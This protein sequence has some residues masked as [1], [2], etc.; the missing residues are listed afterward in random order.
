MTGGLAAAGGIW[1]L[2]CTPAHRDA[3]VEAAQELAGRLGLADAMAWRHARI[4]GASCVQLE[5]HAE[6]WARWMPGHDTLGLRDR[7]GAAT[8]LPGAAALQRE[9]FVAMLGG[10][11]PFA[12][13][14]VGE[15]GSAL[16]MRQYTAEAALRT[17]LRFH[18]TGLERPADCWA[19]QE[20]SGFVLRPN[21]SLIEALR[22]ATQPAQA[23]PLYSFSCYRATE[24][25]L[26]LA[27]AQELDA[28]NP[29]LLDSLQGQWRRRAV[30]SGRFHDVFLREFGSTHEPL[31]PRY[32]VAGDRVWFR[33]P[34]EASSDASGYEGSWTFY[35]GGGE[36]ANLWKRDQPFTLERKCLELYH[37][38]HATFVDDEGE[39]RVDESIVERR[40]RGSLLDR[41]EQASI[42]ERMMR[43]RD[44]R[45]VYA[46]GGCLDRTRECLRWV[47][48]E[49]TDLVLPSAAAP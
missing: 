40:V 24:Y 35:V 2:A 21:R 6:A 41:E 37:W 48:P 23:Q 31:P 45:G 49:T 38:R 44:P 20:S 9:A 43:M 10:P 19:Y 39:L 46:D 33:N 13:P 47:H 29:R 11:V 1:L 15:L 26:L 18:T 32:Y 8:P 3:C 27:L 22:R 28:V 36:F 42:L 34:D 30:A 12:F 5:L 25:V 14:S 7:L 17:A 4:G 16:R